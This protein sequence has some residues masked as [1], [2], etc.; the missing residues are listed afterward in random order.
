L[1]P[2]LVYAQG[3]YGGTSAIRGLAGFPCVTPL[4]GNGE[5]KFQPIHADDLAETVMRCLTDPSLAR[6]TLD[7]V[8]PETV[9]LAEIVGRTR[10]WLD[11][12]P[13]RPLTMP[14][15]VAAAAA[16]IG[17]AVGRGPI[18]TTSLRQMEYGSVSDS[19]A[20]EAAIGFRP[21]TMTQAFLM[22][23]SHVQDR[24]HAR[25]YFLYP[26][27]TAT[28]AI[29]WLGSGFAGLFNP[30]SGSD[31]IAGRLGVPAWLIPIAAPGFSILDIAVGAAL[32]AGRWRRALGTIQ[33]VVVGLYTLG[34]G[35]AAPSL[36]IDPYG[37]LL[38]NLP[39]LAAIAAWMALGEDK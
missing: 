5:Q 34:L 27:L 11:L 25:L 10:A 13:A 19:H 16:R 26:M 4:I 23:P 29:L 35:W 32:I 24:W 30:P 20:F 28:L 6:R 8:G 17:D 9:S 36:W 22:A 37:A 38:K 39:V 31:I 3:S 12:P 2:S 18:R 33:I 1:R 21:R 7:A 14:H 15:W